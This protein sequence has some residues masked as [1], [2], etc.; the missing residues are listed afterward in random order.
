MVLS[1]VYRYGFNGQEEDIEFWE[2]AVTFKYRAEDAR[3]G[4]FFSVDLLTGKFPYFSPFAYCGNRVIDKIDL[5]G[6]QPIAPSGLAESTGIFSEVGTWRYFAIESDQNGKGTL[7]QIS[8]SKGIE[9]DYQ[10]IFG[11]TQIT[12]PHTDDRDWVL[13]N[14]E[15]YD[16]TG[17]SEFTVGDLEA[18]PTLEDHMFELMETQ[19]ALNSISQKV[20]AMVGC[21]VIIDGITGAYSKLKGKPQP[22]LSPSQ[23]RAINGLRKQIVEHK[24][25]LK[26]FKRNP[27]AHD[28]KGIL[29]GK[30]PKTREAIIKA[31][32]RNLENQIKTFKKDIEDIKSGAKKVLEKE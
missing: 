19:D 26:D 18:R 11:V 4:R 14:G 6:L 1:D 31:R 28:N 12:Y 9:W 32:I 29:K 25:K 3:L 7:L 20:S 22:K 15:F 8:Q 21:L 27:D 2:G 10:T 30:D 5:D 16:V 13:W 24:R 23:T 17:L